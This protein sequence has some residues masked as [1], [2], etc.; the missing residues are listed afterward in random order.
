MFVLNYNNMLHV[1][2]PADHL[3]VSSVIKNEKEKHSVPHY[4]RIPGFYCIC[5]YC[6]VIYILYFKLQTWKSSL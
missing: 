4:L 5:R 2:T 6:E 1:L 3:Q